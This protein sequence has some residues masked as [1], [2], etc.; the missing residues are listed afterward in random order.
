MAGRKKTNTETLY[1]V[2]T[3]VE[4]YCGVGAAGVHFAHGEAEMKDG[5]V[6][7]WYRNHGYEVLEKGAEKVA[8]N[9]DAGDNAVEEK[10]DDDKQE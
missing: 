10:A 7:D 5:W 9:D 8:E 4:D 2:K 3:P 6:L 1:I